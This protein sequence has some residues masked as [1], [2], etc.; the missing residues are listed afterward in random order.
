MSWHQTNRAVLAATPDAI[1]TVLSTVE[2]WPQWCRGVSAASLDGPLRIGQPGSMAL[3]LPVV[4]PIHRATAPPMV[5]RELEPGS[6]IVLEQP[7]PG[8]SLTIEWTV[9]PDPRSPGLTLLTQ[10][11]AGWGPFSFGMG[12]VARRA[13]GSDFAMQALRV[14]RL[15]GGVVDREALRVVV[16]G[17]SGT[18]GRRLVADLACRGH[19][20]V[21]LTRSSQPEL[22]V[23]QALWDGASVGDWA[24]EL[25]PASRTAVVNLAGRLVDVRPTPTNIASLRSSRVDST[26]AL[27]QASSALAAPLAVWVQASTTAI[28]SDAG[29]T[30][31]D[32]SS[33]VPVGLPQMTGVAQPWE[34]A[35]EGASAERLHILRTSLVL[36]RGAP[37][38]ARLVS[39]TRAGLGGSIGTGR[40]WI[41]W[42]HIE[43]WLSVVRASL[44][45]EPGV[46]LP[47][48]VVIASAPFPVRN[49]DLMAHLRRRLHRPWSPPTPVPLMRLGA[50]LL[51]TDAA[52]GLTGRRA[53]SSVLPASGFEFD[54]PRLEGALDDLL[55]AGQG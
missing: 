34:E 37:V 23:R 9:T 39:L 30:D 2:L 50:V 16:A 21:V 40:Q 10:R 18:L 14:W 6:R 24:A 36:D 20:V 32:E 8:G 5:V 41:S 15:A 19:D 42:I 28:Y 45:V 26:R 38:M 49:S 35:V 33:S 43:D 17:G 27:V 1:F 48:G 54:F 51:R 52:L 44:G 12:P 29:E 4:G 22:P 25:E 31:I 11:L 53:T 47:E 13:L 46:R 3:G 7:Q 55:D